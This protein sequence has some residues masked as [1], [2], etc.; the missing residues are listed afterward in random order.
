LLGPD[1]VVDIVD[2]RRDADSEFHGET[3]PQRQAAAAS[4]TTPAPLVW[5]A[6]DRGGP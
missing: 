3:L 1:D 4:A 5:A 6:T 2:L